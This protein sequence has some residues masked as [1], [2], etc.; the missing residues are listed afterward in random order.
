MLANPRAPPFRNAPPVFAGPGEVF[1]DDLP[2]RTVG[3]IGFTLGK[4]GQIDECAPGHNT[5]VPAGEGGNTPVPAGEG[6]NTP[7]PAGE[8]GNTPTPVEEGGNDPVPVEEGG[9]DP[10]PVG[11][12]GGENTPDPVEEGGND[13]APV[14]DGGSTPTP[15]E[16]GGGTPVPAKP[17]VE[18]PYHAD[19]LSDPGRSVL[20]WRH[21][22]RLDVG[23]P[24]P[25]ERAGARSRR[26][27]PRR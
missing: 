24:G 2:E 4:H 18:L 11:D 10:V 27:P 5:P 7:V 22:S 26:R 8:G 23:R 16:E 12:G 14:G 3:G 1:L 19:C 20:S 6:G 9:N 13:P 15:V 17:V 25:D 21:Q